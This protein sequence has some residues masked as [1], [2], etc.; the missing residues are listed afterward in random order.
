MGRCFIPSN[1]P[2]AWRALLAQPDKHWK[3]GYSAKTL[4]HCWEA[5][6]QLP[7]E[8][9]SLIKTNPRFKAEDPELLLAIPEWKVPLPGGRRDSQNDALALIGVGD[10]LIVA[11]VEGKVSESFGETIE[12]WFANPSDGKKVRLRY[13]CEK[14]GMDFP[15]AEHLR[16]QLFHRAASAVIECERFRARTPAM[17]VHSFSPVN[18]GFEDYVAFVSALGGSPELD[19]ATEVDLPHG[20]KLLLGWARGNRSFL[21]A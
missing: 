6:D 3:S 7:D 15:P 16:Y 13:L 17:I 18:A 20:R 11:T 10:E 5:D 12:S 9:A 1:G 8:L 21:N 2:A 4:A 14:L 19:R